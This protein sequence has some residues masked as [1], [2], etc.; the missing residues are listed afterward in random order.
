MQLRLLQDLQDFPFI[1]LSM[2]LGVT[3][4]FSSFFIQLQGNKKFVHLS[5]PS[6]SCSAHSLSVVTPK[7][8]WEILQEF[9]P[10]RD[11][12]R[13]RKQNSIHVQIS[14]KRS[15]RSYHILAPVMRRLRE[16]RHKQSL[17]HSITTYLYSLC[18]CF[19]FPLLPSCFE[20]YANP[21]VREMIITP[22]CIFTNQSY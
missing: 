21:Q 12:Q 15:Q 13:V 8:C 14:D 10:S 22:I 17:K 1:T 16:T 5:R 19:F 4:I 11:Q 6:S 18:Y 2:Y 7:W 9:A 3:G 20:N